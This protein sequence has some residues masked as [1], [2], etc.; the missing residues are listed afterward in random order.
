MLY[1]IRNYHFDPDQ[2]TAYKKW[3]R[4]QALPYIDKTLELVGFWATTEEDSEVTGVEMDQLGSAN[5][6]W[7]LKWPDKATRDADFAKA[8]GSDEWRKIFDQVP[9]GLQSYRRMEAKFTESLI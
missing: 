7:I 4:E 9:G 3:A 5:I 6:T 1:E 2:F 8:F